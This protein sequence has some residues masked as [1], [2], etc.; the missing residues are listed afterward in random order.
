MCCTWCGSLV[1][2]WKRKRQ[3]RLP[4]E[5]IEEEISAAPEWPPVSSSSTAL[6]DILR[7]E[8]VPHGLT[9]DGVKVTMTDEDRIRTL[10][11]CS[12]DGGGGGEGRSRNPST[13]SYRTNITNPTFEPDA[14][15]V[16]RSSH[17]QFQ[18]GDSGAPLLVSPP[19]T[20]IKETVNFG[21]L[22]TE[23]TIL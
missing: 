14:P 20:P 9:S 3:R 23:S 11:S 10:S 5:Q 1:E 7:Q 18:R 4:Y 21:N 22:N 13:T 15:E 8:S 19:T 6:A 17:P 2:Q 12:S 16:L